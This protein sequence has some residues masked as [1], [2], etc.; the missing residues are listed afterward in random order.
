M[1]NEPYRW[2][3]VSSNFEEN[4]EISGNIYRLKTEGIAHGHIITQ[5]DWETIE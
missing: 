3:L 2:Y 4:Y 1:T 5:D